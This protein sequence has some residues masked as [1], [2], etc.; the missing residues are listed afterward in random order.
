MDRKL[1]LL[2]S[3]ETVGSD[4]RTYKVMG[5]EHQ[6]RDATLPVVLDQWMPTG[7]AEYRLADGTRVESAS[8]GRL[9]IASTGVTLQM[10]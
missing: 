4:G 1:H 5:Y 10:P 3:F 6:M 8:D 7:V 2:D 9:R